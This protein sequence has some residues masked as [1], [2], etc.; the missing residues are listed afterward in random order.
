MGQGFD[1]DLTHTGIKRGKARN[2][3]ERD[4]RD[5]GR[6]LANRRLGVFL[7]AFPLGNGFSLI[8][9]AQFLTVMLC[10]YFSAQFSRQE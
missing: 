6:I 7:V 5:A 1:P 9:A 2:R 10:C 3:A 8:I 4:N